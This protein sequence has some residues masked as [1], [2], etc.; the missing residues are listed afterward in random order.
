MT[1]KMAEKIVIR[2]PRPQDMSAMQALWRDAFPEDRDG[3]FVPWYFAERYRADR[4]WLLLEDGKLAAMAYAP[5]VPMQIGGRKILLP[6]VQGVATAEEFRRKGHCR[7]LLLHMK[8]EL[9][10][11]GY[12]VWLL[13]PFKAEFYQKLGFRF[14][15]YIR[16][17]NLDFNECF[18]QPPSG[19]FRLVHY[20]NPPEAARD[21]AQIYAGWLRQFP[22][23][24][25]RSAADFRLLLTDHMADRGMLLAAYRGEKPLAY[26]LYTTTADGVFLRE[27]AYTSGRAGLA[28]LSRLAADYREDTPKCVAIMPDDPQICRLLPETNAGWQV[29]PF[30]MCAPLTATGRECYNLIMDSPAYFYEYF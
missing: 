19:D 1:E 3:A 22:V 25:R 29:L 2:P 15:A 30:A 17:Y 28:L 11:M 27:L 14:F 18:L 20:L 16:R 8:R 13:K 12:P 7:R 5:D 26:A 4:A 21:A 6:Y 23:R 9:A 10:G 24:A